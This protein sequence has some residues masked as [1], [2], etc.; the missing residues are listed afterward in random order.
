MT[1]KNSNKNKVST[2]FKSFGQIR[3]M[4]NKRERERD[5]QN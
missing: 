2:P 5:I 4:T 3:W 1:L